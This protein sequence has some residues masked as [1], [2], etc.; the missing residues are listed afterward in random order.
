MFIL[1]IPLALLLESSFGYTGIFV[2]TAVSN[3]TM[4]V[5]GYL[6][7]RRSFFPRVA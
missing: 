6:W 2:A 7:F 4:G 1:Y 5:L 3:C